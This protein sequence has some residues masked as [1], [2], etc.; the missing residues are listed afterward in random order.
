MLTPIRTDRLVIRAMVADDAEALWARRNDPRVAM[1]QNWTAPYP[2]ESAERIVSEV[3]AEDEQD[4]HPGEGER[5]YAVA[6]AE[7]DESIGDLYAEFSWRGRSVEIGYT[8]HPDHWGRGYAVEAVDAF[9]A[10]LFDGLRVTRVFG[11]LHPDNRASAQVLERVG[12]L[13]EG[14]TRSSFWVGDDLSDDWIYGMTRPDWETWRSRPQGP[15]ESVDLVDVTTSNFSDVFALRT[16]K[17]QESFVAP[18]AKSLSQALIAPTRAEDPVT[19]WYRA[20]AADGDIAGFVMVALDMPDEPEPFLWR[21]LVDRM[22]Q[23]RGIASRALALVEDELRSL[24]HEAWKTSW[25]PGRGSPGP[26]YS[27]RGFEETGVMHGDEVEG[28][29]GL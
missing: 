3:I 29:K 17:T 16:H 26:F 24:G 4:A 18:V 23:R 27:A 8:F 7:S 15:P 1:Y 2:R 5:M 10:Y 14:H 25:I 12:M 22:H 28:R 13:H 20:I 19:P 11:T 21:L 9:I 6:L